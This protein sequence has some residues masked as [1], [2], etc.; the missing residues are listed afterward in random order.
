MFHN[1]Q[2][3]ETA[4]LTFKTF[5]TKGSEETVKLT[6]TYHGQQPQTS[7][8]CLTIVTLYGYFGL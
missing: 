3:K 8:F 5:S 6:S 2:G 1:N 4:L 7:H